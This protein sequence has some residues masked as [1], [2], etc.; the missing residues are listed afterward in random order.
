MGYSANDCDR[1]DPSPPGDTMTAAHITASGRT[2]D[3]LSYDGDQVHLSA[4]T[5][6]FPVV[7]S[8]KD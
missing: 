3:L 1:R 7:P 8:P 4:D 2:T 6:A 5:A